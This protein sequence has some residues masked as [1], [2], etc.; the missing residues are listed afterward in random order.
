MM[1]SVVVPVKD[2][3]PYLEQCLLSILTQSYK[4]IEVICIDDGSTDGSSNILKKFSESDAR[5]VLISH[6]KSLGVSAARNTGLKIAKGEFV[7]FVDSDDYLLP[8]SLERMAHLMTPDVDAVVSAVKCIYDEFSS[9]EQKNRNSHYFSLEGKV[10][11]SYGH[12]FQFNQAVFSA[13]YRIDRIKNLGLSFPEGLLWEDNYWH[14]IYFS[15]QPT[16][17]FDS[18][19]AYCYRKRRGGIMSSVF[20]RNNSR[21]SEHF[22]ICR[23]IFQFYKSHDLMIRANNQLV[24]LLEN[25]LLFCLRYASLEQGLSCYHKCRELMNDYVLDVSSSWVLTQLKSKECYVLPFIDQDLDFVIKVNKL[26]QL[27][28]PRNSLRRY[29]F[30]FILRRMRKLVFYRE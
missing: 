26:A 30:C 3:E 9:I 23:Q 4:D 2:V 15:A 13:L 5:V 12:L 19:L 6:D 10:K 25:S 24:K 29:F 20:N 1:I 27:I 21:L 17:Y 14:W 28:L 18:T 11:L 16:I 8:G 7:T 22:D